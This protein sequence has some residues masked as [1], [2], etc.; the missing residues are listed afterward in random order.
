MR[1]LSKIS[2]TTA[3]LGVF[4]LVTQIT[5]GL[6]VAS[7]I[8]TPPAYDLLHTVGFIWIM[9]WWVQK[10]SRAYRVQRIMDM[11]LFLYFAWPFSML[12]YLFKTRGARALFIILAFLGIYVAASAVGAIAYALLSP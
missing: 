12:Y 9:G 5:G 8:E 4:M 2:L 11:A 6:Y 3:L 1:L 7:G 10:D